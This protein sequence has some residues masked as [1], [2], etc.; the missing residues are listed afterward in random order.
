[1]LRAVSPLKVD[2][3]VGY[4][5]TT[6][7]EDFTIHADFLTAVSPWFKTQIDLITSGKAKA[8]IVVNSFTPALFRVFL[9]WL[10]SFRIPFDDIRTGD[11]VSWNA[12]LSLFAL[13]DHHDI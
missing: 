3:R 7:V 8:P 5:P 9:E 1:M 2:I 11:E 6:E 4:R 12:L 10:Y 13:G